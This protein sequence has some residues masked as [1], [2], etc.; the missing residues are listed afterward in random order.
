MTTQDIIK[1]TEQQMDKTID[2]FLTHVSQIRTGRANPQM[3][4]GVLVDAYGTPTPLNQVAQISAPEPQ[5]IVVKPYDK[6]QINTI[7]S[8]INKAGLGMNPIP[9]AEVIRINIPPLTE[10]IRKDVVKKMRKDLEEYKVQIRNER[11]KAIGNVIKSDDFSNDV[12]TQFEKDMDV[13]TRKYIE[14]LDDAAKAKEQQ[15]MTV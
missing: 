2:A 8:G 4:N 1:Q 11:R 6:G 10:E 14:K 7:V 3:L 12:E 13:V 15:L 9:D 5:T